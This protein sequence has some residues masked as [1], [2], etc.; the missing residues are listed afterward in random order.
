MASLKRALMAVPL[1]L[2]A[3]CSS[4]PDKPQPNLPLCRA[5]MS[6]IMS[7]LDEQTAVSA[8]THQKLTPDGVKALPAYKNALM[9]CGEVD[10]VDTKGGLMLTANL[11]KDTDTPCSIQSGGDQPSHDTCP[12]MQ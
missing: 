1:L 11:Y 7:T 2:L 8:A 5:A 10:V 9:F 12:L 3:G 6:A 4:E